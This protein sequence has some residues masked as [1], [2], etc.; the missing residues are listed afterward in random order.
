MLLANSPLTCRTYLCGMLTA[1]QCLSSGSSW[2]CGAHSKYGFAQ[3]DTA[4]RP[5]GAL[6]TC[7]SPG[8]R[9]ATIEHVAGSSEATTAPASP[10]TRAQSQGICC[11]DLQASQKAV[12]QRSHLIP[13]IIT[14]NCS[15]NETAPVAKQNALEDVFPVDTHPK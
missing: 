12:E 10:R 13:L 9:L 5:G 2:K 3:Q 6:T 7:T 11:F 1:G 14:I 4:A 8:L 15:P